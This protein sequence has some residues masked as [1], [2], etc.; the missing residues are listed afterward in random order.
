MMLHH[1]IL[2]LNFPTALSH[3][4]VKRETFKSE[5]KVK[6]YV[7]SM[8]PVPCTIRKW[9]SKVTLVTER[10]DYGCKKFNSADPRGQ[11]YNI[12][13]EMI[14]KMKNIFHNISDANVQHFYHKTYLIKP[15]L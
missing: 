3:S 10:A 1:F 2:A 11:C 14:L 5:C 6:L 13:S 15:V 8:T 12:V 9:W 7:L 4:V